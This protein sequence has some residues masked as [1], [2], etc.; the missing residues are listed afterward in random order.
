MTALCTDPLHAGE[1]FVGKTRITGVERRGKDN[2]IW[3]IAPEE[4]YE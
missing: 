3:L 2:F 4:I 1:S